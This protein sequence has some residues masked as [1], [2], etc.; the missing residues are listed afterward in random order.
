MIS[1]LNYFIKLIEAVSHLLLDTL[2]ISKTNTA[3]LNE[4]EALLL[5]LILMWVT[6]SSVFHCQSSVVLL[7][8]LHFIVCQMENKAT[9][10][11]VSQW[12]NFFFFINFCNEKTLI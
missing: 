12:F 3:D 5:H 4:V 2:R 8:R 11:K 6:E 10:D 7:N 9:F 1:F